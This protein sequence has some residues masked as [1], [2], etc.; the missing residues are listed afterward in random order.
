MIPHSTPRAFPGIDLL[1]ALAALLVLAY[2]VVEYGKWTAMPNTGLGY[3]LRHG[4]AGVDLF[5]TIS[6]FVIGLSALDGVAKQGPAF[7]RSFAV[8]RLARIVPLYLLTCAVY[9]LMVSPVMLLLS[10]TVLLGHIASHLLFVHNL[11]VPTHG[12][13]NGP[14]WSVALEMQF[15]G[16]IMLAAP[17]LARTPAWRMLLYAIGCGA[18]WRFATTLMLEP[19][20]ASPT[21]QFIYTTQLPGVIDEFALGIALAL[22]VH[23]NTGRLAAWLQPGWLHFAAW[24]LLAFVLL[25]I[26][27]RLDQKSLY[28]GSQAMVVAWRPLLGAGFTALLAAAITFPWAGVRLLAPLRY[29]GDISYGIYLWHMLVLVSLLSG[30]P[31]LGGQWLLSYALGGTLILAA[32]TWHLLEKPNLQKYKGSHHQATRESPP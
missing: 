3:L 25:K 22:V 13:I 24:L 27:I 4:W 20:V 10:K 1:R 5:F 26:A 11:Y 9:L 32:L 31:G 7:R 29:L 28:W 12:S 30:I 21:I 17:W 15:Y 18:L 23:R 6:G 8:R 2:H 14:S 19:G 16:A